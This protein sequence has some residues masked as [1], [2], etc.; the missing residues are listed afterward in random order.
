MHG[1]LLIDPKYPHN[2][3]GAIR[4]AH[5]FGAES[6]HWTGGR[7]EMPRYELGKPKRFP[8][9]E[10]MKIYRD[11]DFG[12]A[13]GVEAAILLRPHLVPVAV[14]RR[15]NAEP[16][17]DF[18]HPADALYVFGPED[19]TLG[20]RTLGM[21]HRFVTIPTLPDGPLNLAA[22]VNVVLYD[23]LA[24]SSLQRALA[25]VAAGRVERFDS[26]AEFLESL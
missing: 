5:L 21:C 7:V 11:V 8:R 4:A 1:V 17:T 23:R 12:R 26:D 16:L 24:K 19:G 6:V 14:E 10:R 22:A 2:V 18:E 3:G 20:R 25:D 13:L 15:A 9:E